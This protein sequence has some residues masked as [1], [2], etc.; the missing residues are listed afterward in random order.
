MGCTS[1]GEVAPI[2]LP[3]LGDLSKI[4][5]VENKLGKESIL[6]E[7]LRASYPDAFSLEDERIAQQAMTANQ[8]Q[9]GSTWH[10]PK[11]GDMTLVPI[12]TQTGN[13]HTCRDYFIRYTFI[14]GVG[15]YKMK[16]KGQ[17]CLKDKLW[18]VD[19]KTVSRP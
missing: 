12:N 1:T 6:F 17:A 16:A 11:L 5:V 2:P 4:I 8:D 18:L 3:L 14:G 9:V 13:G 15:M 7:S 10:N 19:S